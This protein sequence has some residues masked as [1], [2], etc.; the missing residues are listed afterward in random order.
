[1]YKFFQC[2]LFLWHHNAEYGYYILF[3]IFELI[4]FAE[5]C[6]VRVLQ[7]LLVTVFN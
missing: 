3:I 4:P 2:R 6:R 5:S 1:M 7:F